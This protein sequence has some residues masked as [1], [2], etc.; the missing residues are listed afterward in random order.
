[1]LGQ[2]SIGRTFT[3]QNFRTLQ[4]IAS[5][6]SDSFLSDKVLVIIQLAMHSIPNCSTRIS[7]QLFTQ[8]LRSRIG[9][10]LSVILGT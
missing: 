3:Q 2:N 9:E 1:M 8:F 7:K 5:L 6:L 4:K 10:L